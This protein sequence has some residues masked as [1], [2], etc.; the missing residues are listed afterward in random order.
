MP[1]IDFK[2]I[3]SLRGG[4]LD[5]DMKLD[6]C[7]K[8]LGRLRCKQIYSKTLGQQRRALHYEAI[9]RKESNA[10]SL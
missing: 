10:N 9:P 3:S 7:V 1:S 2:S 6:S 8:A 4:I 5:H